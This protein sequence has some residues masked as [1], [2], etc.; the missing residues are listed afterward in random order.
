MEP[1]HGRNICSM[2]R[3]FI[4]FWKKRKIKHRTKYRRNMFTKE[5]NLNW[6]KLKVSWWM[7]A[8]GSSTLCPRLNIICVQ[9]SIFYFKH[10]TVCGRPRDLCTVTPLL[11]HLAHKWCNI[12]TQSTCWVPCI[13]CESE[14]VII[15]TLNRE[16]Q[17][18]LFNDF[19]PS[20]D[21]KLH[22]Q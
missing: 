6:M 4:L 13:N 2:R 21:L 19:K 18:L 16:K 5:L 8:T 7:K 15:S 9:Y 20:D 11:L 1:P 22:L 14:T 3:T 12:T 17:K 10:A